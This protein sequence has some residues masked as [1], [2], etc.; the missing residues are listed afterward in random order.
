MK[1]V[2][3]LVLEFVSSSF[4]VCSVCMKNLLKF[5]TSYQIFVGEGKS[6]EQRFKEA[7][8]IYAVVYEDSKNKELNRQTLQF[9]W[10]VAASEL[11]SIYSR[12]TSEGFMCLAR[13][14]LGFFLRQ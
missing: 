5:A 6:E 13:E 12:K 10:K 7:S 2:T 3:N 14:N 9:A 1:N 8:A 11:C 4:A